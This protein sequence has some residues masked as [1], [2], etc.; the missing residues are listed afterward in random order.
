MIGALTATYDTHPMPA[1]VSPS[2]GTEEPDVPTTPVNPE[3]SFALVLCARSGDQ[4]AMEQL[5]SRY[6]RRLHQW[7]HSR[8][9]G[10]ARSM[11]DT[12]DLVQD[13][14]MQVFRQIDRFEPRH[15]GA[16]LGYVR[17]TLHHNIVN[18]VRGSKGP[19]A[20]E[21]LD[22]GDRRLRKRSQARTIEAPGHEFGHVVNEP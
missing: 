13:T 16:F 20:F 3:S 17:R 4:T 14:M 21:A 6:S 22:S 10:W 7:A 1:F 9:P 15:T 2:G 12:H 11:G 18:R 5:F 8:L 19:A